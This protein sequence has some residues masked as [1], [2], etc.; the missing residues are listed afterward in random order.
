MCV[1]APTVVA[2]PTVACKVALLPEAMCTAADG[3]REDMEAALYQV[4]GNAV[5]GA[6]PQ[7]ADGEAAAAVA[8]GAAAPAAAT[9]A[10]AAPMQ[11][12]GAGGAGTAAA[13]TTAEATT[14]PRG[15]AARAAGTRCMWTGVEA[16]RRAAMGDAARVVPGP[17]PK[18]A[19]ETEDVVPPTLARTN[20][21]GWTT[22]P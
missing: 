18:P 11:A 10:A 19:G 2:L 22:P 17:A 8:V 5:V 7:D 15:D 13:D 1:V 9:G 12:Q 16:P 14:C 3:E 21:E 6:T 20:T 4:D